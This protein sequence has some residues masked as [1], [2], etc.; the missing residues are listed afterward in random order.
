[1]ETKSLLIRPYLERDAAAVISL[2]QAVFP[3]DPPWNDPALVIRRKL[4]VQRGL[5]LVGKFGNR[6]VAAALAGFDGFRGWVYHLAVAPEHR[7]RG[8]GRAMMQEAEARLRRLG[9]PKLNLQV[10]ATNAEVIEFY[11]QLGYQIEDRVSFGKRL[12]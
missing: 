3:D 4:A 7:R 1:M 9:C 2:W 5:F 8:Y 6:V 10:R 12:E 11:R